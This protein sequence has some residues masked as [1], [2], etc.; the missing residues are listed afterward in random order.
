MRINDRDPYVKGR[1]IDL[2]PAG[3]R[4]FGMDCL[5]QVDVALMSNA[6]FRSVTGGLIFFRT[7]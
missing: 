3:G 5:A 4:A 7:A 1:I 2:T 6:L